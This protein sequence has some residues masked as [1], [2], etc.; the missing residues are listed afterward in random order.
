MPVA[1]KTGTDKNNLINGTRDD[2]VLKGLGGDDTLLGNSGN[3]QLHGG[4]GDDTLSGDLGNDK[5][6]GEAGNDWVYVSLGKDMVDGGADADVLSFQYIYQGM[7]VFLANHSITFHTGAG[8]STTQF[9]NVEA[10]QGT[11]FNDTLVG[12][13]QNNLLLGSYGNDKLMGVDGDDFLIGGDGHETMTG[14]RGKDGYLFGAKLV[15][16]NVDKVT[17]FN[18]K[19]DWLAFDAQSYKGV[20]GEGAIEHEWNGIYYSARHIDADQFQAGAG[21]NAETADIR[22]IYDSDDGKLYYDSNGSKAGGIGE[23]ADIGK[24]H[25]LSASDIFVF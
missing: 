17:D 9:S 11:A 13:I 4:D 24:H 20:K 15:E 21:H 12:D 16:A 23:I 19:D 18:D 22:I 10:L 6:Y 5:V 1:H 8:T 7:Q 14:G 2:D 25:D 3:D